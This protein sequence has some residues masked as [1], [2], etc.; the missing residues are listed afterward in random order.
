MPGCPK[1]ELEVRAE[2]PPSFEPT[3]TDRI[4]VDLREEGA[5]FRFGFNYRPGMPIPTPTPFVPIT[6]WTFELNE[7]PDFGRPVID[8][9]IGPDGVIWAATSS[10]LFGLNPVN[11]SVTPYGVKD[12]LPYPVVRVITVA[13]D[14]MVW[15]GTSRGAAQM[16]ESG[17]M[18]REVSPDTRID[19]VI[20]I[21]VAPDGTVWFV[22]WGGVSVF[23]PGSSAW[24]YDVIG[25]DKLGSEWRV[26]GI[27]A[28]PDGSL[29]FISYDSLY[30]MTLPA[31]SSEWIVH[32]NGLDDL[33]G[34]VMTLR[35]QSTF[36]GQDLW[37]L[38]GSEQGP[39]L[40]RYD[41]IPRLAVTYN[42]A[43]TAGGM[44]GGVPTD[45]ARAPDGSLWVGMASSG[46]LHFYPGDFDVSSG[47]W[48]HYGTENGL[49]DD[50]ISAVAVDPEGIVWLGSEDFRLIRCLV[51]P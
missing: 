46:V 12:G 47:T 32:K 19:E 48:I 8:I 14:G 6:C 23:D 45:L 42:H 38:G 17:W 10:G 25:P 5:H 49:P 9:A 27:E 35:S 4:Q 51:R 31:N 2:A 36:L 18:P 16:V 21:T 33:I 37:L 22:G 13:P 44:F 43:T 29:W 40:V 34:D 1:V 20:D 11:G 3:T 30:Q 28:A 41:P 24:Q 39:S 7:N 15:I 50:R 26:E